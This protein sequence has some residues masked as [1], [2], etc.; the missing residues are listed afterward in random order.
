MKTAKLRSL[1]DKDLLDSVFSPA[2]HPNDFMG[3]T[4]DGSSMLNGN[5]RATELMRRA[6]LGAGSITWDTPIYIRGFGG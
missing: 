3:V 6:G 1:S 5:H 4:R 2:D